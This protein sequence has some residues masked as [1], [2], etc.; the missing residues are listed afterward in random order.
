MRDATVYETLVQALVTA[1]DQ[2]HARAAG[3]FL[4]RCLVVAPAHRR[5][6]HHRRRRQPL[7]LPLRLRGIDCRLQ[8]AA[9]ITI[10]GPPP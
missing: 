8:R 2:Y 6:Q 10:P 3:D 4:G 5:E 1:A 7:R 9:I